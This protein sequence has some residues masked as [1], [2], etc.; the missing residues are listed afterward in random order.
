MNPA[1]SER[2]HIRVIL[3]VATRAPDSQWGTQNINEYSEQNAQKWSRNGS[4]R[5]RGEQAARAGSHS[6]QC[7]GCSW[8]STDL[9]THAGVSVASQLSL[10]PHFCGSEWILWLGKLWSFFTGKPQH[11]QEKQKYSPCFYIYSLWD[12]E[13]SLVWSYFEQQSGLTLWSHSG[14]QVSPETPQSLLDHYGV[15]M[16][17]TPLKGWILQQRS[18]LASPKAIGKIYYYDF[19]NSCSFP[20]WKDVIMVSLCTSSRAKQNQVLQGEACCIRQTQMLHH[21]RK[22]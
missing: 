6:E 12:Y 17:H 1:A 14:T 5:G 2:L 21:P 22:T 18:I 4:V 7:P 15:S 13:E 20:F 11:R 9:Y 16:F 10:P 3:A 19:Q 8:G